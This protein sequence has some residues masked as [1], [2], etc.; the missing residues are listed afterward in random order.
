MM[1]AKLSVLGNLNLF[2]FSN[3]TMSNN[4]SNYLSLVL[5]V[6]CNRTPIEE[7]N[8]ALIN[9][10]AAKNKRLSIPLS[11]PFAWLEESK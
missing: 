5:Q 11:T 8:R 7:M 2:K 9:C 4:E 10:I 1:V 6:E 3:T